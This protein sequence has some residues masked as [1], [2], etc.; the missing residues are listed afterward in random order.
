[1]VGVTKAEADWEREFAEYVAARSRLLCATA[2]LLCGDWHRAED[3]TQTT[4]TKLYLAWRRIDRR[5]SVD[6]YARQVLVRAVID[7][8]RR[9]WRRERAVDRLPEPA[10]RP[11]GADDRLDLMAALAAL[12]PK[13]R[14]AVVLRHWT[15]LGIAETAAVLG[16]TPGTVKSSTSKGLAALREALQDS[17]TGGPTTGGRDR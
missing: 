4:L 9:P 5:G 14:A 15:D 2:Y 3:H 6:A 13:Q 7:E 16:V 1:V 11:D 10:T 17:R 8:Q 12:P